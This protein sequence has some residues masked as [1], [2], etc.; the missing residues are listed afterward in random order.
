MK[1]SKKITTR[2]LKLLFVFFTLLILFVSYQFGYLKYT[3]KAD[4][5]TS[6]NQ[7]L[8]G[9]L[10]ELEK[11]DSNREKVENET[12]EYLRKKNAMLEEFS[13]GFTQEKITM[14]V[15]DLEE[16]AGM[17]VSSIAFED[18][19]VFYSPTGKGVADSGETQDTAAEETPQA[20]AG[21]EGIQ[22]EDVSETAAP[23]EDMT[24]DNAE[25]GENSSEASSAAPDSKT[26][27]VGITGYQT[28]VVLSY[29]ATYEGLK[30]CI[31]YINDYKERM[32]ISALTA[33]FDSTTGNL[34]GTVTVTMYALYGAGKRYTP[35]QISGVKLGTDNIFGTF[36]LPLNNGTNETDELP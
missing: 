5:L 30:K 34:T 14:F 31:D 23:A 22:P 24:E 3:K 36:E 19:S 16:Y 20:A 28:S 29:Q 13:G 21:G 2:E 7:V 35:P 27:A 17:N 8:E 12:A 9:R 32:N 15:I 25:A 6:E 26:P 10:A 1:N 18:T 33:S 11:K 4:A